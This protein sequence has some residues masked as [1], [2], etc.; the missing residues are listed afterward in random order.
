[1]RLSK[2]LMS[3]LLIITMITT[4]MPAIA[5]AA[6]KGPIE[7][8]SV[9][10]TNLEEPFN[11]KRPNYY[12]SVPAGA[13]YH[14]A[15]YEEIEEAGYNDPGNYHNGICWIGQNGTLE[16]DEVFEKGKLYSTAMILI[17]DDGYKFAYSVKGTINGESC[18]VD[19][20]GTEVYVQSNNMK[21]VDPKISNVSFNQYFTKVN[22]NTYKCRANGKQIIAKPIVKNGRGKVLEEG[23]D[24]TVRYSNANRVSTGKYTIT[25]KGIGKYMGT[26]EKT[27]IITPKVVSNVK[28]RLGAYNNNGGGYDDAYVTWN[29]AAGADGYYVYMRRPNIKDNAWK[30][31]E[32][33]GGTSLLQKNLADGYKYE[34]KV[35]PYVK[36]G[37]NYKTTG[38]FKTVSVQTLMKSKINTAKKYNNERTR[39]TWT[40]V[41]GVTGYQVMVSAKGNTRYFTTTSTATNAKVVRNA[42]TTFKVRGYKDV[43]NNSGKTVRVYAPWSDGRT[44]T[45]K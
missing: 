32:I 19:S 26:I 41:K 12:A 29:K 8:K 39:L 5:F 30:L 33:V 22:D 20:Y 36:A 21:A 23:V 42:K 38:D 7:I 2:K 37:I 40:T 35:L 17:P 27:L 3:L 6:P 44:Y 18:Y 15:S 4:M 14:F 1:M 13:H 16:P 34:F 25:V 10:I 11:G 31:A 43:K 28:V 9:E 24:Y 45:L